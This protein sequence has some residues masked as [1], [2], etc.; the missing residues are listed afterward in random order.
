MINWWLTEL[1]NNLTKTIRVKRHELHSCISE[2]SP[3]SGT[4]SMPHPRYHSQP[5]AQTGGRQHCTDSCGVNLHWAS[6]R[7]QSMAFTTS[8][9]KK[10][11]QNRSNNNHR[12]CALCDCARFSSNVRKTTGLLFLCLQ[13]REKKPADFDVSTLPETAWARH[14][15]RKSGDM[16]HRVL[17]ISQ[18]DKWWQIIRTHR[19]SEGT[20]FQECKVQNEEKSKNINY[21]AEGICLCFTWCFIYFWVCA[22]LHVTN[23]ERTVC[24]RAAVTFFQTSP[25]KMQMVPCLCEREGLERPEEL[26]DRS[27]KV[28]LPTI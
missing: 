1:L 10:S 5:C 3:C 22:A 12:K 20:S 9:I 27:L 25:S 6:S 14:L 18:H 13:T 2:A 4:S 7:P 15:R 16:C 11:N 21:K 26:D 17:E 28:R 19:F 23:T 24:A 8:S